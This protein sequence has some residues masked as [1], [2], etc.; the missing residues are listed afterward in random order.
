MAR[1]G[2]SKGWVRSVL[3]WRLPPSPGTRSPSLS[4]TRTK[5]TIAPTKRERVLPT[6]LNPLS[7][8]TNRTASWPPRHTA[9]PGDPARVARGVCFTLLVALTLVGFRAP[10]SLLFQFAFEHEHY[11]HI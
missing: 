11:S 8:L 1:V 3:G 9:R 10:L 6:K 2:A 4:K 5:R 7:F